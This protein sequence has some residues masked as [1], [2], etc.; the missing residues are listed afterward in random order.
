MSFP[1]KLRAREP[2]V[3]NWHTLSDPAVAEITGLTEFDVAVIDVEHTP[4]DFETAIEMARAVDAAGTDT[5]TLARVSENDAAEIKRVLDIGVDGV[6]APMIDTADEARA[7]VEATK[8]PPDGIRGVANGRASEY[9]YRFPEYVEEANDEIV[10]IAQIETEAGLENVEEIAAV[11]GVDGLFVG[12][13]DLSTALGITADVTNDRF[14]EAVD[15]ILEA[16]HAAETAVTTLALGDEDIERWL[17]RGFDGLM[18]GVDT[19]YVR[20]AS[21]RTKAAFDDALDSSAEKG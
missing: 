21:Q 6:M 8:Y 20:A 16:G 14:L 1:A 19:A 17:E 2:I 15:R 13:A 18:V 9:G 12:P 10:T 3:G 11:E 5:G 7:F 4:M